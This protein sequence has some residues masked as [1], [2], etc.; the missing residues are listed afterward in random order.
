MVSFI[1]I[2]NCS[3]KVVLLPCV[4]F[5]IDRRQRRRGRV[6]RAGAG[7]EVVMPSASGD[8]IHGYGWEAG[9][10]RVRISGLETDD[11]LASGTVLSSDGIDRKEQLQ[12]KPIIDGDAVGESDSDI[13]PV[14]VSDD[15]NFIGIG[16]LLDRAQLLKEL[17]LVAVSGCGIVR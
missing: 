4:M 11:E 12:F 1:E 8:P 16:M 10:T 13:S 17:P 5:S 3:G 14:R 6:Q 9:A 7:L 15:D 2:E